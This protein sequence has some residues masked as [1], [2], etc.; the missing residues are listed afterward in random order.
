MLELSELRAAW[1]TESG[2]L[3]FNIQL[4]SASHRFPM[5][6]SV[7]FCTSFNF[8]GPLFQFPPG[9]FCP[10]LLPSGC[11]CLLELLRPLS[12]S[13][14]FSASFY[15]S[16]SFSF[17]Q[18]PSASCSFLQLPQL[19]QLP[20]ASFSRHY[21]CFQLFELKKT[22]RNRFFDKYELFF[23][24]LYKPMHVHDKARLPT[25]LESSYT[26]TL[27]RATPTC[28]PITPPYMLLHGCGRGGPLSCLR[29]AAAAAAAAAP[30]TNNKSRTMFMNKSS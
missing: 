6:P 27:S 14:C 23:I 17:L 11:F 28:L 21:Y 25:T 9:S 8:S 30:E 19:P 2:E 12:T 1:R 20:S 18:L 29:L 26:P 15:P 24:G 5:L 3:F 22:L 10:F 4:P 7:F 16:A 13:F